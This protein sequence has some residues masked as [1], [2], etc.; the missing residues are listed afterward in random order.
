[1]LY[2][3]SMSWENETKMLY[4]GKHII[5]LGIE[6]GPHV[7]AMIDRANDL[8]RCRIQDMLDLMPAPTVELTDALPL[9]T[10]SHSVP[11]AVIDSMTELSRTPVVKGVAVLPDACMAGS[12][13]SISVGGVALSDGLHPGFHSA[14]ICCSVM[15]S[16]SSLSPDALMNKIASVAHFG[17]GGRDEHK[18]S[19]GLRRRVRSNR[20]LADLEDIG[21]YH[22]GTQG[23][24]NHFS[25]V[26][27]SEQTGETRL[28]THHG[29]RG[30]GARLYKKGMAI[31]ER[32]R[33]KLSPETL[34][35]NAWIP[36]DTTDFDEYW[37][38]LMIVQEWTE[39]NH[40]VVH[41]DCDFIQWNVHNFVFE[42]SDGLLAHAKGST[43]A[44]E[45]E[46]GLIPLNMAQPVLVVQGLGSDA[47]YE[48]CPHG[49][50]RDVSRSQHV[51]SGK[52]D[53]IEEIKGLDVRFMSGTPDPSELPSAYK[54][55][56]TVRSEIEDFGLADVKDLIQP[57]GCIMSGDWQSTAPWRK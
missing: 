55:A 30:F 42:W 32:Y 49:A 17:P 33:R 54:D 36:R 40:R 44:R 6:S 53:L 15:M 12:H 18:M 25:F 52:F 24:G 50:G 43:P 19:D 45:G 34:K 16:R 1:M 29:S 27:V 22:M 14:D 7:R 9:R 11:T 2:H 37:D 56:D 20:L 41:R 57:Y 51:R 13:G 38:A 8:G 3:I 31:A 4:T 28:V 5:D 39:E 10:A 26:G 21:D 46:D 35:Q 23:D 47:A 48:F